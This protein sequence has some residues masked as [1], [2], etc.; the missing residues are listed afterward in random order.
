MEIY[1][2]VGFQKLTELELEFMVNLV[3]EAHPPYHE[4]RRHVKNLMLAAIA[5]QNKED[6]RFNWRRIFLGY[7]EVWK[8]AG[9]YVKGLFEAHQ[10]KPRPKI[11]GILVDNNNDPVII[12]AVTPRKEVEDG[13]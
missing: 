9:N 8:G 6:D 5:D 11:P 12:V 3:L 13:R 1:E 10:A 4:D 7:V 2:G